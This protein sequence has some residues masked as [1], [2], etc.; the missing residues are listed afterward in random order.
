L[1]RVTAEALRILAYDCD[2]APAELD[3]DVLVCERGSKPGCGRSTERMN[4]DHVSHRRIFI[5]GEL[6]FV[7]SRKLVELRLF[8]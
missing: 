6:I 2:F 3:G 7:A 1:C 5:A 8:E 4:F